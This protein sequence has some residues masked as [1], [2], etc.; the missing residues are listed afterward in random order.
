MK[1]L[2]PYPR[3]PDD[4]QPAE[5]PGRPEEHG[6][7]PHGRQRGV[8]ERH[9]ARSAHNG[10]FN[11]IESKKSIDQY[12]ADAIA[13]DTPLRSLEL[14]TEDMGTSAGACDGYP[15]VFF[16]TMSWYDDTA[17]C[18]SPSTRRPRSSACS[19]TPARRSSGSR[20]SKQKQSMLDSVMHETTRLQKMIGAKDNAHPRRI[21]HEHP[22]RR[23][24]AA[25]DASPFER[26]CDRGRRVP[27]ASRRTSTST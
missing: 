11:L 12:I 10:D 7:H 21:P 27:S 17:R 5:G 6:R 20:A 3:L 15:C 26:A 13:G 19:A 18:R 1:P 25:E 4:D 2:E 22:P 24:A 8:L 14:G 9:R 23:R 16:N